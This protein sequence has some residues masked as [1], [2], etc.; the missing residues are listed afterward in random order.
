MAWVARPCGGAPGGDFFLDLPNEDDEASLIVR[1]GAT[2]FAVL[3]AFPYNSG[4]VLIAPYR[5][6][7]A[8]EDL[9]P[10]EAAE[11]LRL[12]TEAVVALKAEYRPEGLNVGL[13]LG[14]SAG[15]GVPV[16][17]HWH[18]VPR[19]SADANFM[20]TVGETRVL[21][22]ALPDTWRRLRAAWPGS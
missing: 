15:A 21:P 14:S 9:T 6:V 12:V 22:E 11:C 18:V 10:D 13:N 2:A 7:A 3:N 16:H 8:L 5:Q 4:H 1:R 17:L 20:T 19:W